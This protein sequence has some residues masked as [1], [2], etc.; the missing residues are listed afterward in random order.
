MCT[1][2]LHEI[3]EWI[4]SD[5]M[6]ISHAVSTY[7]LSKEEKKKLKDLLRCL[8]TE[9]DELQAL[10]LEDMEQNPSKYYAEKMSVLFDGN[11]SEE[12]LDDDDVCSRFIK[13]G[14][15][16]KLSALQEK[17]NLPIAINKKVICMEDFS[18]PDYS[19]KEYDGQIVNLHRT[20]VFFLGAAN[21]GKS[22]MVCSILRE[23]SRREGVSFEPFCD[24]SDISKE[25]FEIASKYTKEFYKTT[26]PS[27]PDSFLFCQ[28]KDE[29]RK[30]ITII[31]SGRRGLA[32]LSKLQNEK[33]SEIYQ[34]G[35][36]R[37]LSNDNSKMLFFLI[38]FNVIADN[39]SRTLFHQVMALERAIQSLIYDGT[40]KNN[41][42]KCTMSKVKTLGLVFTKCDKRSSVSK[43]ETLEVIHSF[44]DEHLQ[45]LLRTLDDA[46]RK[47]SIN[48]DNEYKPYI[49]PFSLGRFTVGNTLLYDP[50]DSYTLTE[51]ILSTCPK[52]LW[53]NC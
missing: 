29:S 3:A 2:D 28:F 30:R 18:L 15:S 47:Y 35:I 21:C 20:D 32:D 41:T 42:K 5:Q 24:D 8:G 46:C 39:N 1:I 25:F 22:S 13:K 49:I 31:D 26:T 52:Q 4:R 17:L 48:K 27:S 50:T 36:Y 38:D 51:L 53:W 34:E 43:E 19:I 16:L 40:G 11:G 23:L 9:K 45:N 37:V 6:T 14:Y 10:L 7:R 33:G 44:M 12:E